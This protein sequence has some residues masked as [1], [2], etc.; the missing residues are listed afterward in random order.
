[1]TSQKQS[2]QKEQEVYFA[3]EFARRANLDW[4]VRASISEKDAP[5]LIVVAED[6]EFGLEHTEVFAGAEPRELGSALRRAES[7]RFERGRSILKECERRTG[8][9]LHI[10]FSSHV[11]RH[12]PERIFEFD[13]LSDDQV[14]DAISALSLADASVGERFTV[15]SFDRCKIWTRVAF[16]SRWEF[17]QDGVGFVAQSVD[18]VQRAVAD[19]GSKLA[20]YRSG[21]LK[22]V[23][24]LVVANRIRNSGK[25]LLPDGACV[26]RLGFDKVYFFSY[27]EQTLVF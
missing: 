13:R 18:A 2:R 14:I 9:S 27:P 10:Q 1:M 15:N 25:I 20:K 16:H 21:G 12:E 4:A 7:R 19:K 3:T 8:R 11:Y 17:I 6:G 5:D 23:R 24:L 26:D 22:D